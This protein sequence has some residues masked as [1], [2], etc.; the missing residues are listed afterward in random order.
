MKVVP[1]RAAG[2]A[3][4]MSLTS[5]STC[6]EREWQVQFGVVVVVIVVLASSMVFA[7]AT[8]K[9]TRGVTY[10]GERGLAKKKTSC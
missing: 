2:E 5:P 1:S 10:R 9:P 8:A 7:A 6:K 3:P 4:A